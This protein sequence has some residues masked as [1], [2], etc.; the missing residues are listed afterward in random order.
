VGDPELNPLTADFLTEYQLA[1]IAQPGIGGSLLPQPGGANWYAAG[2]DAVVSA[3]AN[4][5]FVFSG[6]SGALTGESSPQVLTMNAPQAVTG[7]FTPTPVA[8]QS[9]I[10]SA[11]SG[12]S[13][14]RQWTIKITNLGP[15]TAYN[16][17]LVG[18][19]LV[20]TSGTACTPVRDSPSLPVS[21]G[22]LALRASAQTT[23]TFDFSSCPGNAR[24]A[25]A[26]GYV[27]NG[28]SSMTVTALVN[29]AP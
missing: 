29:Q 10:I 16:A 23:V 14:A 7:S 15:G 1:M 17:Q 21:L 11:A 19:V 2:T 13:N 28:G 18:L 4:P 6:F 12:P 9:A 3:S 8:V 26:I 24:F 20:Q 25:V 27:A 22:D 5:G